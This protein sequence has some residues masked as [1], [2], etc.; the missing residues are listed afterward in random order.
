MARNTTLSS[1]QRISFRVTGMSCVSCAATVEKAL[2]QLDGVQRAEVNFAA[3][4]VQL[5]YDP[6]R[7]SL[8][9]VN[10]VIAQ[11]G[12]KVAT[13]KA[14][15]PVRGMTCA[16]CT[17][18]VEQ[19]LSRVPGVISAHVNLAAENVVV[20]H[21]EGIELSQLRRAV[22]DAGYDL[23]IEISTLEDAN[24]AV[25]GEIQ[26]LKRKLILAAIL[27]TAVMV[28][29]FTPSFLAKPYVL[30]ALATP[31]QFWAG[32]QFYRGAWAASKHKTSDMNTLIAV[33]TSAAY[34]YS[35]AA[36]VV[37]RLFVANMLQ[38]HLYFD[39]SAVIIA[40]V[41]LGRFLEARAKQQSSEA[42]R[43]LISLQPNTAVVMRQGEEIQI[44][45]D[46][47]QVGDVVIVHPGER[48]PVDGIVREGFSTVDQSMI[49][50]ESIPVE[51]R[52]GDE[53]LAATVNKSGS[54][55]LKAVKVGRDTVLAQVIRM[56][57]EAQGSKPPIQRLADAIAG[58]FVP[59]VIGV[60]VVTF[61]LWYLFGPP[62][63]FTCAL[64]NFVAVLIIACPCALGLATPIAVTVATGKGAQYGILIRN[65][66]ALQRAH[67]IKVMLLDKTG[68]LTRGEPVVTD[69]VAASIATGDEVLRLAASAEHASEHPV[70]Q[71]IVK[72]ALDK[73]LKL[74]PLSS[75]VALSGQGVEASVEGK[76]LV[77]GNLKLMK[78]QGFSL[79]GLETKAARFLDEGKTVVF[80]AWDGTVAGIIALADTLKPDAKD[81]VLTLQKMGIET[82]MLSGDNRRTAEAVARE[83][84]IKRVLAEV[85]PQH[86]AQEVR[87]L[88]QQGKTVA[89]VGDGIN[90]APALAKADVG[91]A[92]GTGADVAVETADIILVKGDLMG[93]V[94]A[95]SLSKQTMT[96]IKQNLFWAFAYN[97][98]LIPVAAGVLYLAL[99]GGVPYQLHFILGEHGFLNPMIAAAAMTA[100]SISV[101]SN[102]LRLRK[103][104]PLN[105]SH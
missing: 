27:A 26:N 71:A 105:Y 72:A 104:R 44:P 33:G 13:K 14:V 49:T 65:G 32:W 100:S 36:V 1:L 43:K 7:L 70:G 31:V 25:H 103:F 40:L 47:I 9:R 3:G 61:T 89:V 93:V 21:T 102:S 63:A 62:P 59:A 86:K 39:T 101:V 22:K 68:T 79:N 77:L 78:E 28:L 94:T 69:V 20:E 99:G 95:V 30:W 92:I 64:L 45:V 42:I 15:F 12:Y 18:R 10:H 88:Q 83:A 8:A 90:D 91:I 6:Q 67:R 74:S 73:K 82:V 55:Q 50:G 96:I 84:G 75:F 35:A 53:V 81:A 19:A 56:V 11:L 24:I 87:K 66:E 37:P 48:I 17:T 41:L 58:Y 51:K 98:A 85:L 38:P 4:K 16:S 2:S 57:E 23:G 97:A 76:R 60:G 52:P 80:V 34:L 46:E 54:L 5:D 29:G